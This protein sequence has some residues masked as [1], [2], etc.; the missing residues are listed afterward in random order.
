MEQNLVDPTMIDRYLISISG[1][2]GNGLVGWIKAPVKLLLSV[3]QAIK[4]IRKC[5]PDMVL[6]FGGFAS[7]PGGIAA[8]ILGKSLLIHE[9]NAVAGLTNRILSRVAKMVIEAFPNTFV[10]N[11]DRE[12]TATRTKIERIKTMGNPLRKDI[13]NLA[14]LALPKI[15]PPINVLVLG[16]S[17]GAQSLNRQVPKILASLVEKNRVKVRH[18]CGKDKLDDTQHSYRSL[19]NSSETV[20]LVEFIDDM[21]SAYQWA[22]LVICR[23]GALTVSEIAAVGI[24][25]VFIPY[26]YAVDDHQTY[27]AQWLENANAA[28]VVQETDLDNEQVVIQIKELISDPKNLQKMAANGRKIAYKNSTQSIAD[29]CEVILGEAA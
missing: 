2:R 9:Q 24:A 13:Q 27:N 25:A 18:Q 5:Q 15:S 26:P 11:S 6:G 1:L 17:R 22:D 7:G 12:N 8:F 20:C 21:R 3:M 10:K 4:I 14:S 29:A 19:A 28:I 16:G 23:A